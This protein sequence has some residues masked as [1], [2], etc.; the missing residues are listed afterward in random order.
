MNC[1]ESLSKVNNNYISSYTK[2]PN[3]TP[4]KHTV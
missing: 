3:L 4:K 2:I 1:D